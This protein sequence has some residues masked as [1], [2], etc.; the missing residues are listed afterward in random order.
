VRVLEGIIGYRP[1]WGY[2]LTSVPFWPN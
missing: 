1:R 2:A